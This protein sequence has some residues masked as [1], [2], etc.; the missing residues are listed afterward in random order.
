MTPALRTDDSTLQTRLSAGVAVLALV[1]LG[2]FGLSSLL[3]T[4]HSSW[5]SF[6]GAYPHGYLVL[7]MS[8]WLGIKAWRSDS[9]RVLEPY[10]LAA[11]PLA[12]CVL[13]LGV[14]EVLLVNTS[15]LVML[16][17]MLFFV[18]ALVF[19]KA[20]ARTLLWPIAFL[21][22][23]LPQWWLINGTLQGLTTFAVTQMIEALDLPAYVEGNFIHVPEGVFEV[24]AGCAGLNYVVVAV[25]LSAFYGLLYLRRWQNMLK[26]ALI[27]AGIAILC[28]WLRVFVLVVVGIETQMQHYLIRV[29]HIYFGWVMFLVFM[30]PVQLFAMRLEKREAGETPIAGESED[31]RPMG[32]PAMSG[33]I[34][35]AAI[36][37]GIILLAPRAFE[38]SA[39]TLADTFVPLPQATTS[40]PQRVNP[41]FGWAP[42]FINASEER[43]AYRGA[44]STIEVY[45][46]VYSQQTFERRLIRAENTFFGELWRPTDARS[47]SLALEGAHLDIREYQGFSGQSEQLVWSWYWVAGRSTSSQ[48]GAKV[49]QLQGV[50]E[51][52]RDAVAVA[53]ATDCLPNCEV[54]RTRLDAFARAN[55]DSLQW[56]PDA[57][58]AE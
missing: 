57:A 33:S 31:A 1:A 36:V 23:A 41:D 34:A 38:P 32:R 44:D 51:N 37:A 10:W 18:V 29:D 26:L 28:N 48:L 46:A 17:P 25:A 54:A 39:A 30:I 11:I 27:A 7:G 20:S 21:Y 53:I 13:V 47:L 35:A 24:A 3:A 4:L 5:S 45:R 15:R 58:L 50:L 56:R 19:G 8:V 55:L 52:R 16:P 42:K 2:S 14:L 49:R 22:F 12:A 40:H 43:V 9:P 6:T